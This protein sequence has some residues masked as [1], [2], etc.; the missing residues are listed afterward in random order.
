MSNAPDFDFESV[1]LDWLHTKPGAKWNRTP[2]AIAAWVADMDFAPPPVVVEAL[3]RVIATGDLGYPDHREPFGGSA[4]TDVFIDRCARR[5]GWH[6]D[7][8][9]TME[10]NDVVQGIQIVLHLC[11]QPGDRVVVH[12]PTYPPFL[13]SV[14]DDGRV[15]VPVPAQ[16]SDASPTGWV[17]DYEALDAT[18]TESPAKVL[19]L[20]HPHNPTGHVF[21][22]AELRLMAALAERH[23]LL[24]ISDEIHADLTFGSVGH[25]P[26]DLFAPGRTVTIHAASKAF[27]LAALRFAILHVDAPAVSAALKTVP[28]HLFGA[29]NLMGAVATE[30]AWRDGDEWLA[31]VMAHLDRQRVLL[32]ALLIEKLPKVG[33]VA[34]SATY[35]AWLDCRS[36]GLGDDPSVTF[37]E[38]GV[39]LSEG[40]NFGSEGNGFARLNF[41]TSSAVLRETVARMAG[42]LR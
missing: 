42:N 33:Y 14:Q 10:L 19:L 3:Q 17:F 2:D 15:V 26:M 5:Y 13:H 27:N 9:D 8:P 1:S 12:T 7:Q 35:L 41:A 24:I 29:T 20:C 40:P 28:A 32:G 23:D 38:R 34:P 16:R 39:R 31:A 4:A 6:I 25:Q 18:L 37:L 30:A 21:D 36:L 22:S 11:T